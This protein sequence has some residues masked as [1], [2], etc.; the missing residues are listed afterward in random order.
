MGGPTDVADSEADSPAGQYEQGI[1]GVNKESHVLALL[2]KE[3]I[4]PQVI[5]Y[6]QDFW[7][8]KATYVKHKH[9]TFATGGEAI[10]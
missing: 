3:H 6:Q 7:A 2:Q 1:E 4:L 10:Q 9:V 5:G 8:R